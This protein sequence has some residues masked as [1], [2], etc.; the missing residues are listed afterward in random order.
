MPQ[1]NSPK[2]DLGDSAPP[3]NSSVRLGSS[4][5]EGVHERDGTVGGS[6]RRGVVEDNVPAV[7]SP[8]GYGA[9]NRLVTPERAAELREHLKAKLARMQT[10][11]TL[12]ECLA[13]R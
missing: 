13:A 3:K 2:V 11:A 12:E 6:G 8:V 9:N 1:G 5:G 7:T 4:G 10:F